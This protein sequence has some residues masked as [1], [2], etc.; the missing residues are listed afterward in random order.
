VGGVDWGTVAT[1]VLALH[2]AFVA[3]VVAGGY[4][5][6]R[7]TKAIVPHLFAAAWGGLI[8]LGLVECPLTWAE[9]WARRKDG[10]GPLT[11]GFVDRY[12]DNVLYPERYLTEVRLAVALVIALSYVGVYLFWR[13]RQRRAAGVTHPDRPDTLAKSPSE[14]GRATTV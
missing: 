13:R 8:A 14:G 7:W 4:L 6:W 5:A 3:Y 12:L 2:F 1:V 10:Q 9:D 11:Q